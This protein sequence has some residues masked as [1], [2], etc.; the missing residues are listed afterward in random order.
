MRRSFA[1]CSVLLFL[2]ACSTAPKPEAFQP[3]S[4]PIST[5]NLVSISVDVAELSKQNTLSSHSVPTDPNGNSSLTSVNL[6]ITNTGLNNGNPLTFNYDNANNRYIVSEDNTGSLDTLTLTESSNT[7]SI[8]LVPSTALGAQD[9]YTFTSRGVNSSD[10]MLAYEKQENL[11]INA[12]SSVNIQLQTLLNSASLEALIP[13]NSLMP[14]QSLELMLRNV[15]TVDGSSRV[16]FEDFTVTYDFENASAEITATETDSSK[17]GVAL[18]VSNNTITGV[19][20]AT[21]TLSG[22]VA[23]GN[24]AVAGTISTQIEIPFF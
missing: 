15:F 2:A 6:Q 7:L 23:S 24:D 10:L 3:T 4:V 8:M 19:F 1:L 13:V 5:K 18:T 12:G 20:R 11:T 22:L 14:S 9:S 21:A 16:P 17:L